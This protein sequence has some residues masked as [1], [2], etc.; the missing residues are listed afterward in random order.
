MFKTVIHSFCLSCGSELA[1]QGTSLI[2]VIPRFSNLDS[3]NRLQV[4]TISCLI[5]LRLQRLVSEGFHRFLFGSSLL[6]DSTDRLLPFLVLSDTEFFQH[7]VGFL[8]H[9]SSK[10]TKRYHRT[11]HVCYLLRF[12]GVS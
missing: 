9:F 12:Y 5:L 2:S 4:R 11:V 3:C 7:I 6:I 1:R 10:A 8:K